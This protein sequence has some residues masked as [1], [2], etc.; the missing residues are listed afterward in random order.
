MVDGSNSASSLPESNTPLEFNTTSSLMMAR[1][2]YVSESHVI[3]VPPVVVTEVTVCVSGVASS[4]GS[5]YV[6]FQSYVLFGTSAV[7]VSPLVAGPPKAS[8]AA[9]K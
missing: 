7:R 9:P 4:V 2:P 3:P 6:I 5:T 8:G 1:S